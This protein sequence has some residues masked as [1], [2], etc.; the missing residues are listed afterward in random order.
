MSDSATPWTA[1]QQTPLS[2]IRDINE[3]A[4]IHFFSRSLLK[5]MSI[6][7]FIVTVSKYTHLKNK[8]RTFT[9]FIFHLHYRGWMALIC[10]IITHMEEANAQVI[11]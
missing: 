9:L 7:L 6:E 10:I 11:L 1:A 3:F 8:A 5:F 4:Q 2:F